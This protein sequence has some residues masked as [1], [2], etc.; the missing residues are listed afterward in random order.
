[1]QGISPFRLARTFSFR[2]MGNAVKVISSF[3]W[4]KWTHKAVQRGLPISVSIEPTTSCNLR[5]PECPS[6]LRQ[7]SRPT[8]M[9]DPAFFRKTIDQ[10]S[11]HLVYLTFYFQGEPFLNPHFLDMVSYAAKKRIFTSTSTNAHF[12]DDATAKRTVE[13][14]LERLIISIDGTTQ[15]TYAAYRIGGKLSKV[16]EGTKAVLKWKKELRSRTPQV[17]F[18]FLV[19]K[20]NEH[21]VEDIHRLA[22][23]LGVDEVLLKTAQVY[24]YEN[25]N[26]LIPDN[27]EYSRYRRKS[28]G[29]W[30][31]KNKLDDHCWK[32]WHSCVITWNGAVVPCCFDKDAQ[33]QLGQLKNFPMKEIWFGKPYQNFRKAILNGRKEID[34]CRNCSEGT[35]VWA[36]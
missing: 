28:D 2:R 3:Y 6:G 12:L 22:A 17:V 7:F 4:S 13:S 14:G 21:Q 27:E 19:V 36:E 34:I 32:M 9:L 18:Q 26:E 16:I 24:E 25:G 35:K 11:P 30:A 10:L 8:G 15:E 23:D 1:M 29:T 31:I 5:C 20:P 33:H